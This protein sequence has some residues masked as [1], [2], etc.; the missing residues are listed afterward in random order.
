[1]RT[2]DLSSFVPYSDGLWLSDGLTGDEIQT[3][4]LGFK[5]WMLI[6][7]KYGRNPQ[8]YL[9]HIEKRLHM[10][11]VSKK[12]IPQHVQIKKVLLDYVPFPEWIPSL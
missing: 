12:E 10:D 9:L 8:W 1:M 11:I 3:A 2:Y 4:P 7:P 6:A 5:Y